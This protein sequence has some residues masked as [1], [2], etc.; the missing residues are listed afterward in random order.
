MCKPTP[1]DAEKRKWVE[2]EIGELM[3]SGVVERA[4]AED[5]QCAA[6]LVLVEGQQ[7]GQS[8]R[9][10]YNAIDLNAVAP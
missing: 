4:S 2:A 6:S 9:V 7:S 8:Y 10:C 1:F 5:V 3:S